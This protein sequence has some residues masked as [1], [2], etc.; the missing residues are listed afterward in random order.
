MAMEC[1]RV[2]TGDWLLY[3]GEGRGGVNAS[4]EF[5]DTLEAGW[6]C[7]RVIEL[8]PFRGNFEKLFIM[9]RKEQATHLRK[10]W[11]GLI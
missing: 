2:Y 7:E 6:S 9:R 10:K 11:L 4:D 1:L 5:F 8:R 3:V